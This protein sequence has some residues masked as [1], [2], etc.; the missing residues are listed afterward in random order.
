MTQPA[1]TA[2]TND[3]PRGL[4]LNVLRPAGSPDC[5]NNGISA[6]HNRVTVVGIITDTDDAANAA[7]R[8][9]DITPRFHVTALPRE[10]QVFAATDD[11]PAVIIRYS[12]GWSAPTNDQRPIHL[13][14]LDA[15]TAGTWV[16]AG[17]NY[18]TTTDSRWTD[19][20]RT[21]TGTTGSSEALRIHDRI[22]R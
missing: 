14:P 22:E 17:G 10:C 12:A 5:T 1:Q 2:T 7:S 13:D 19:L 8:R 15:A 9:D 20:V 6:R 4:M 16:M 18:A 11:A 3:Q 21:L